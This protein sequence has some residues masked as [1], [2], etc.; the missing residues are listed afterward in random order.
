[1]F[2]TGVGSVRQG[3][4]GMNILGW[5]CSSYKGGKVI[6]AKIYE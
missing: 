3:G 6:L 1:M 5:F 4:W 2:V